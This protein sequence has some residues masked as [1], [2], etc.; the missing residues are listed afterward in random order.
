[1]TIKLPRFTFFYAAACAIIWFALAAL[2]LEDQAIL[3]AGFWPMRGFTDSNFGGSHLAVPSIL[4]PITSAFLHGGFWHLVSNMPFLLIAGS[5]VE[6]SI[7]IKRTILLTI[8]G[9][10]GSALGFALYPFT[11]GNVTIGASGAISTLIAAA[12]TCN[13]SMGSRRIGKYTLDTLF[14]YALLAIWIIYQLYIG[15]FTQGG[16]NI[17]IGAHIGGFVVGLLLGR[18]FAI[19]RKS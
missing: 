14:K 15:F 13:I 10:F 4:T 1:M 19:R 3:R 12:I 2:G 9:S 7:G 5:I 17:A 11:D 18:P 6:R 8:L 16:A